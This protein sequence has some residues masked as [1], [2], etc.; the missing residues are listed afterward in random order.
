MT[1]YPFTGVHYGMS[2]EQLEALVVMRT[3]R[4]GAG[5]HDGACPQPPHEP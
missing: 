3:L 4:P 1:R 5:R 2:N